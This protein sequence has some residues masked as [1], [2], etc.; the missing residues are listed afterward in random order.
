[1]SVI[2]ANHEEITR[3]AGRVGQA[4]VV[5]QE[6]IASCR[7]QLS[8]LN[9]SFTGETAA[10]FQTRYEEWNT[11][12]AELTTALDTLGRWL[13]ERGDLIAEW[14]TRNAASVLS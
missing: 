4:A 12:A 13:Q 5:A 7:S 6:E 1:M 10:A 2:R 8:S 3:M 11:A 14:D 9:D